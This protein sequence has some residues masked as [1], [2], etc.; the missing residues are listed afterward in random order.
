MITHDDLVSGDV[1][2]HEDWV[3][4]E[5]DGREEVAYERTPQIVELPFD[6]ADWPH[7]LDNL[8]VRAELKSHPGAKDAYLV[9]VYESSAERGMLAPIYRTTEADLERAHALLADAVTDYDNDRRN[10]IEREENL[11]D[12]PSESCHRK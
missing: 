6:A 12:S 3:L 8:L 4:K 9:V 10:V 11:L 5:I 1:P 2:E 7:G